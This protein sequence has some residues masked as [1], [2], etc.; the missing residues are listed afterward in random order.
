MRAPQRAVFRGNNALGDFFD[1]RTR[2]RGERPGPGV[3][4]PELGDDVEVRGVGPA[5]VGR[6]ADGHGFGVVFV[7]CVLQRSVSSAGVVR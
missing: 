4:E 3:G 6:D 5:V 1:G 7:F 2:G